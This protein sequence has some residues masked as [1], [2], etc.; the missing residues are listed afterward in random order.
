MLLAEVL[1]QD[2][3]VDQ[4]QEEDDSDTLGLPQQIQVPGG[5]KVTPQSTPAASDSGKSAPE[6][7]PVPAASAARPETLFAST[8]RGIG[9]PAPPQAPKGHIGLFGVHPIVIL[10]GLAMLHYFVVHMVD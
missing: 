1:P 3:S 4:E 5:P 10:L 6:V 9:P 7:L 8:P 2:S